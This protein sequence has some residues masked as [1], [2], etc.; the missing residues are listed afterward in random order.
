VG[1]ERWLDDSTLVFMAFSTLIFFL[2][3]GLRVRHVL[4]RRFFRP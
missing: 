3:S 2:M 4:Q 1:I